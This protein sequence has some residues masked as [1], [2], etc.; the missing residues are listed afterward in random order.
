MEEFQL[1]V[2]DKTDVVVI[3]FIEPDY[4]N[5]TIEVIKDIFINKV[6]KID[7]DWKKYES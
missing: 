4:K 7:K 6:S 1:D 2:S 3:V 5:V